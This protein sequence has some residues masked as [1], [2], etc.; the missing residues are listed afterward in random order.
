MV[1]PAQTLFASAI[2][3]KL[4][5][6]AQVNQRQAVSVA[7]GARVTLTFEALTVRHTRAE[8]G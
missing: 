6:V 1:E 3:R 5:F 4:W 2:S 7:P 8:W